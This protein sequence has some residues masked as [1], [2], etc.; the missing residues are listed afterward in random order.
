MPVSEPLRFGL[1][2]ATTP[3]S[4]AGRSPSSRRRS[5]PPHRPAAGNVWRRVG[6]WTIEPESTARGFT[7]PVGIAY[8]IAEGSR[9]DLQVEDLGGIRTHPVGGFEPVFDEI[10]RCLDAEG[11]R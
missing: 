11:H 7:Q 5:L 6:D 8:R 1:C 9:V 3:R 2:R 10:G 4:A